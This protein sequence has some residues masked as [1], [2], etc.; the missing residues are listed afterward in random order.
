M[1]KIFSLLA[2]ATVLF[3]SSCSKTTENV[4][5]ENNETPITLSPEFADLQNS[6]YE[7]NQEMMP[8]LAET[9][10]WPR[11]R[12]PRWICV[13]LSDVA[14]G[15]IGHIG[16][17]SVEGGTE[18]GT[19]FSTAAYEF[20]FP[21]EYSEPIT[22][23]RPVELEFASA[24]QALT[25][26]QGAMVGVFHNQLVRKAYNEVGDSLFTMNSEQRMAMF[27]EALPEEYQNDF[28]ETSVA[29]DF[30]DFLYS[31]ESGETIDE[32]FNGVCEKYPEAAQEILTV[33]PILEGIDSAKSD[34]DAL[35]YIIRAMRAIELSN[36]SAES[37]QALL[38]GASIA[39]E[40]K[41]L[42]NIPDDTHHTW[43]NPRN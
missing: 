17:G 8:S 25:D 6:L 28:L 41:L 4:A 37:K 1:K 9:R 11:W 30:Q 20:F 40:S 19:E 34:K 21:N 42:W 38:C 39:F 18:L 7:L 15:L 24:I 23:L 27:R 32:F 31:P 29:Y 22:T 26:V 16:T 10:G 33:K 3:A 36:I 35:K 2:V 13:G 12:W 5:S 14:G 43:I